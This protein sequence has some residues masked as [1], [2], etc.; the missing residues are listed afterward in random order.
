MESS[1]VVL[2]F[3]RHITDLR[4]CKVLS[5]WHIGLPKLHM[6][7]KLYAQL[8]RAFFSYFDTDFPVSGSSVTGLARVCYVTIWSGN[9]WSFRTAKTSPLHNKPFCA[10]AGRQK[11]VISSRSLEALNSYL[12]ISAELF[13]RAF[14][15]A[16]GCTRS[17]R[18]LSIP[19]VLNVVAVG[20]VN[21]ANIRLAKPATYRQTQVAGTQSSISH[22]TSVV[23]FLPTS[24][25]TIWNQSTVL[26][27]YLTFVQ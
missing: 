3:E 24:C 18:C 5:D 11:T 8:W 7:L 6:S 1:E 27:R 23:L 16:H 15:H 20:I 17:H 14:T 9:K 26:E 21:T 12:Q 10:Q 22:A 13:L 2:V 19:P 25:S 4:K